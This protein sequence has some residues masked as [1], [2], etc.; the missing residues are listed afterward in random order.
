MVSSVEN[1]L[2]D[3]GIELP[4]AVTPFGPYVPAVQVGTLL[5]LS[6]MLPTVGHEAKFVGRLGAELNLEQVRSAARAATL[7]VLA[8][9]KA[10][11]GSL[12]RVSRVVRLGV[13]IATAGEPTDLVKVADAA[14][15]L[16]RDVLGEDK[17]P[18]RLVFGVARLPLN[19]PVELEAIV[20]ISE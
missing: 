19:T 7:N 8:V 13:Y 1:R 3:M 10:Q 15:E 14:S 6:G 9:V 11:F 18:A 2:A 5:F 20:E 17:I 16:L 12:E 4:P